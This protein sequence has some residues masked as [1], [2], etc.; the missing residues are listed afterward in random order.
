MSESDVAREDASGKSIDGVVGYF[1]GL[2][3]VVED[4][5]GQ[6]RSK[7]HLAGDTR[8]GAN[9]GEDYRLDEESVA[10]ARRAVTPSSV[11]SSM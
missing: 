9:I 7:S 1:D 3:F 10:V 2:G 4:A 8:V 11:P 5:Y 6:D